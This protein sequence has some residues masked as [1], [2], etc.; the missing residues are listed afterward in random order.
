MTARFSYEFRN[1]YRRMGYYQHLA[2][3]FTKIFIAS[4]KLNVSNFFC[5][6]SVASSWPF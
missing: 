1:Q 3:S 5:F 2:I 6:D 4:I